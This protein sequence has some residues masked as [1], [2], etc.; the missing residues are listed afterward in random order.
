[1][2]YVTTSADLNNYDEDVVTTAAPRYLPPECDV[3]LRR[4]WFWQEGEE[5]KTLP[6][7]LAIH[8]RSIGLGAN[9]LLN[10]PPDRRGRIDPADAARVRELRDALRA[11]FGSPHEGALTPAGTRVEVD[12]GEELEIEHLELVERLEEG[13]RVSS[14]RILAEDGTEIVSGG[15]VGVRRIHR[16]PAPVRAAR[17]R[18]ELDGDAPVLEAVRA[19][20]PSSAPAP[21]LTAAPRA[22]TERPEG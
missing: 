1:V 11:R 20:P 19:H 2:Q 3:S 10:I 14:H 9:L 18:I 17:L 22:S 7:L 12:L 4:G 21:D 5:P 13:Q 6:H 15:T 8:D 16:L